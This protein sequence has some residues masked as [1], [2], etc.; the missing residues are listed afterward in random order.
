MSALASTPR[1]STPPTCARLAVSCEA[2]FDVK[3]DP[4]NAD[5]TVPPISRKG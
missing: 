2:K 1:A 5:P 4:T 3:S